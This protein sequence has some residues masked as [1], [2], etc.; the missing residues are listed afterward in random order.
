MGLL[1]KLEHGW[2]KD[3][4]GSFDRELRTEEIWK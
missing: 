4:M 1:F 2:R 3:G